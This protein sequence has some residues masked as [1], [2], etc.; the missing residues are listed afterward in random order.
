[1]AVLQLAATAQ[2]ADGPVH[3]W[4]IFSKC[5]TSLQD[6]PRL[7]NIAW[8]LAFC[9]LRPSKSNTGHR[10][11]AGRIICKMIPGQPR[12]YTEE[13]KDSDMLPSPVKDTSSS[14]TPPRV[15]VVTPTPNLTPHPT[16]PA[17]PL[18][19]GT[20]SP[21]LSSIQQRRDVTP[22]ALPPLLPKS[23]TRG[24]G[25][26]VFSP[27]AQL[28]HRPEIPT[29][30]DPSPKSTHILPVGGGAGGING[31]PRAALGVPPTHGQPR[32]FLH[33]ASSRSGSSHSTSS[34]S[35]S[36][37]SGDSNGCGK[38]PSDKSVS[39]GSDDAEQ[40]AGLTMYIGRGRAPTVTRP[41]PKEEQ[42]EPQKQAEEPGGPPKEQDKPQ[43]T[44]SV[45]YLGGLPGAKPPANGHING[46]SGHS[47]RKSSDDA[48]ADARS[49]SSMATSSSQQVKARGKAK[50]VRPPLGSRQS[51]SRSRTRV[52][53]GGLTMTAAAPAPSQHNTRAN[54][55]AP[56]ALGLPSN[57]AAAAAM[58]ERTMSTRN[59]RSVVVLATSDEEDGW[60]DDEDEDESLA[61]GSLADGSLAD[62]DEQT[63]KEES[64]ENGVEDEDG[65]WED[66]S[67]SD[68]PAY[69]RRGSDAH[70]K[71]PPPSLQQNAPHLGHARGH[72]T[73]GAATRN[74]SATDL[75]QLPTRPHRS[76]GHLPSLAHQPNARAGP[77]HR[78]H[79]TNAQN[80]RT[81]NALQATM[82]DSRL[83]SAMQEAQRQADMFI[84]A[85]RVSYENLT[86]LA[87]SR[88]GGLSKLLRP[89][90][91]QPD[92]DLPV[93]RKR[94]AGGF[95]RLGLTMTNTHPPVS[96]GGS[97][98]VLSPVPP[99][100][101][102]TA[103]APL[104]RP[105][106]NQQRE[107]PQAIR[108]PPMPPR[109]L[110]TPHLVGGVVGTSGS[111]GKSSVAGPII[112]NGVDHALRQTSQT[113]TPNST[114]GSGGGYRPKGPPAEMEYDDD[115]D[116]SDADGHHGD[117]KGKGRSSEFQLSKSVAQE[118]LRV[119]AE[120]SA[121]S[122]AKQGAVDSADA[123]RRRLYDEAGVAP[124]AQAQA[125]NPASNHYGHPTQTPPNRSMSSAPVGF[126]Y[127]LPAPAPP[128]TPRTT[129]Q[130]MLANE[131]SESLRHNLLWERKLSRKEVTG[132]P[133]RRTKSTV[134]VLTTAEGRQPE[135]SLVRL[136]PRPPGAAPPDVLPPAPMLKPP[137]PKKKLVRNLSWAAD[138]SDYHRSGW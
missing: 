18:L 82:S 30:P 110:T 105:Q 24:M 131:M 88:P 26:P 98:S 135:K 112:S 64:H 132:P 15:V 13:S 31:A 57:L 116:E 38:S 51:H 69:S 85:P 2:D 103:A 102:T 42:R 50:Q 12:M 106:K 10:P 47:R 127:N 89:A 113:Q 87:G 8:R 41:P 60:S 72:S 111:L 122:R 119:L 136:T 134:N 58:V 27:P 63:K 35:T 21:D 96:A 121:I 77:S 44:A 56:N 130:H 94:P 59:L 29:P 90:E 93:P 108:R 84:K 33:V 78:T 129:R 23:V 92:S 70:A 120:R 100:P 107:Q 17:T 32:F 43:R 104:P 16:P 75:R 7:Q 54:D 45:P 9:D 91:F 128:T 137:A 1:M 118:K 101:A 14:L 34:H 79:S 20:L 62:G 37:R 123:E 48:N 28:V 81:R 109:A 55:V 133:P 39:S 36:D 53:K 22:L 97:G 80:A 61:D 46:V 40:H 67:N 6:G 124:W 138:T 74:T 68:S 126:P 73:S 86:Q 115:D 66:A 5:A 125:A 117:S 52:G 49:V 114:N 4:R 99:T 95:G 25:S 3:L 76:T 71:A 19:A 65:D 11:P 83:A